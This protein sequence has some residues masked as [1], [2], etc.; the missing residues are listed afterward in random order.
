MSGAE[1]IRAIDEMASYLNKVSR[2]YTPGNLP[3]GNLKNSKENYIYEF[4]CY[5]RFVEEL[6]KVGNHIRFNHSGKKGPAFPK[7]PA[8]KISGW[9]KFEITDNSGTVLFDVCG[10]VNI[11]TKI[12]DY[13]YAADI[14]I[15]TTKDIPFPKD[16]YLIV[17]AKYK[18]NPDDELPI[19]QLR[20]FRAVLKDLK[21]PKIVPKSI[22]LKGTTFNIPTIVTNGKKNKKNAPYASKYSFN[23]VEEFHP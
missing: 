1:L 8:E 10:G 22:I 7:S 16:V 13:T 11:H 20:E 6:S 17:D 15:Q 3:F 19:S 2:W 14:S 23:Q 12:D 4:Y 9:A 21:F 18:E 5:V